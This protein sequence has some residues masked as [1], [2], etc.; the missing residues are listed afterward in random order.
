MSY[1]DENRYY[2]FIDENKYIKLI[3][4]SYTNFK[5]CINKNPICRN[6]SDKYI[7]FQTGIN[8]FRYT[9]FVAVSEKAMLSIINIALKR[10]VSYIIQNKESYIKIVN[11]GIELSQKCDNHSSI[12][13]DLKDSLCILDNCVTDNEYLQ[14]QKD[15]NKN[16]TFKSLQEKLPNELIDKIYKQI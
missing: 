9:K 10:A 6:N 13:D 14:K 15:Y 16:L 1:G 12:I 5:I 3:I 2:K 4:N 7:L 8:D 11:N